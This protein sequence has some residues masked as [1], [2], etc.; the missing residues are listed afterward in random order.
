MKQELSINLSYGLVGIGDRSARVAI[1]R[2][3]LVSCVAW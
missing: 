1:G 2:P 3:F